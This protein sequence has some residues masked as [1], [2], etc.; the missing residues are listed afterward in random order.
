MLPQC[1]TLAREVALHRSA[2]R[3]KRRSV[4]SLNEGVDELQA[5]VMRMMGGAGN[6]RF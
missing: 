1:A 6:Q 2:L 4:A 3:S 5:R